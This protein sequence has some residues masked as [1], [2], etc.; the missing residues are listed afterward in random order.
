MIKGIKGI[1]RFDTKDDEVKE[2]KEVLSE[3]E[4]VVKKCDGD[5]K[6]SEE[7]NKKELKEKLKATNHE[8]KEKS[9]KCEEYLDR[10]QRTVAEFDN[11]KR[12]TMKEKE[13][14]YLD[15]LCDTVSS[16]LPVV[17][18]F[19]RAILALEKEDEEKETLK[20]GIALVFKQLKD[21]MKSLD[22]DEIKS[23]GEKFDPNL[24]NAV[25]HIEDDSYAENEVIEEFQ[26]GYI[27]K[28]RVIRHSMVKV[29][30]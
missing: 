14:M 28:D 21:V 5:I 25:M 11:Y 9:K 13:G 19:E 24:H 8:L 26:K 22:V 1:K 3:N 10:L 4:E 30:N 20:D 27:V 6:E 15:A 7:E 23:V 29:A 2:V 17:D 18:N 16:F 12:R